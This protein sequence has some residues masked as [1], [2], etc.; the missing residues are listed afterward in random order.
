[1]FPY[2][3]MALAIFSP[4]PFISGSAWVGVF[5]GMI[6]RYIYPENITND[7]QGFINEY[8]NQFGAMKFFLTGER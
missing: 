5:R 4:N 3:S 2:N 8:I 6:S 1:M 7:L